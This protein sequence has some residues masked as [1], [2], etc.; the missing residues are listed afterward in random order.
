MKEKNNDLHTVAENIIISTSEDINEQI[1]F[2]APWQVRAFAISIIL[3][4]QDI[5]DWDRFSDEFT[6]SLKS[7]NKEVFQDKINLYK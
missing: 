1:K 2:D 5:Y 6:T 4:K 3:S 7:T